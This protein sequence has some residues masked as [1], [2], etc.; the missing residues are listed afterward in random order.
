MKKTLLSLIFCC[1]PEYSCPCC[2]PGCIR[3]CRTKRGLKRSR[4]CTASTARQRRRKLR[5]L[6]ISLPTC[7][8]SKPWHP[9]NCFP[10]ADTPIEPAA[11]TQMMTAYL[12]FKALENGTLQADQMLT[13]SNVGWKVEGSR[14]FLDPKV[15]VQRQRF[16]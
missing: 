12:A 10:L 11:L 3:T 6:P 8:A 7:T 4:C 14:M 9:N 5:R 1:P 13:V 16:D 15:P 2:R